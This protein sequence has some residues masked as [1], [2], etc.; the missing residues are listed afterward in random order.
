V[1]SPLS[2][3]NSQILSAR[4]HAC[5][6]TEFRT[7][8]ERPWHV[9][10]V[11]PKDAKRSTFNLCSF[12]PPDRDGPPSRLYRQKSTSGSHRPHRISSPPVLAPSPSTMLSFFHL[13]SSTRAGRGNED[14]TTA[15][16]SI[17]LSHLSSARDDTQS[18]E[19][20]KLSTRRE[21]T[22]FSFFFYNLTD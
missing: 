10:S 7:M 1:T 18:S 17:T 4:Q 22:A 14:A 20:R 3:R 15:S 16:S 13:S 2:A 6:R 19:G 12:M 8:T 11:A 21:A 9:A 5:T